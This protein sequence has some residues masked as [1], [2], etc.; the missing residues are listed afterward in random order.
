MLNEQPPAGRTLIDRDRACRH[1]AAS[2]FYRFSTQEQALAERDEMAREPGL[3]VSP[4][5]QSKVAGWTWTACFQCASPTAASS[6]DT[7]SSTIAA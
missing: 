1:A 4:V 6:D 2:Q 7:P 3:W 5:R